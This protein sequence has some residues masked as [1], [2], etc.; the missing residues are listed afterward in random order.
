MCGAI[1]ALRGQLVLLK[2]LDR[3][4]SAVCVPG[5]ATA[6]AC[7]SPQIVHFVRA[8]LHMHTA[9]NDDRTAAGSSI[10]GTYRGSVGRG[11]TI[12]AH[13]HTVRWA[14]RASKLALLHSVQLRQA[15]HSYGSQ[16][17]APMLCGQSPSTE[18]TTRSDT[19]PM[20]VLA[21]HTSSTASSA[22]GGNHTRHHR[23]SRIHHAQEEPTVG[24]EHS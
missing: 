17:D 22:G 2:H 7:R 14:W 15:P 12:I 11:A 1:A 20:S 23:G 10:A 21:P 6:H 3:D 16:P 5:F 19:L 24:F 9:N 13:V 8:R 18:N 4:G